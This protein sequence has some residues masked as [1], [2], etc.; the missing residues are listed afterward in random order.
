[1]RSLGFLAEGAA[2]TTASAYLMGEKLQESGTIL[3]SCQT[4]RRRPPLLFEAASAVLC[5]DPGLKLIVIV[6]CTDTARPF[7][8]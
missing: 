4:R 6:L 3:N 5:Y 2:K 8:L 7:M 1:M